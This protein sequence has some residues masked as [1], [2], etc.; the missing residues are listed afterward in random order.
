L[1]LFSYNCRQRLLSQYFS[2]RSKPSF[3]ENVSH[4]I[5]A[6]I[7][8]N[9]GFKLK[10]HPTSASATGNYSHYPLRTWI[11]HSQKS[12]YWMEPG[13]KMCVI[14][15]LKVRTQLCFHLP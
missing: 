10:F 13:W 9:Q 3:S 11:Q 2:T 7:P 1:S 15:S 5:S 6:L 8:Q 12:P 14:V 4:W